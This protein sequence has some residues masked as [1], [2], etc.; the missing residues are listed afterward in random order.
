MAFGDLTA[1]A[2]EKKGLLRLMLKKGASS[3]QMARAEQIIKSGRSKTVDVVLALSNYS[4]SHT[5]FRDLLTRVC[6]VRYASMPLFDIDM[7]E[8]A[9]NV[10]WRLLKRR[11]REVARALRAAQTVIVRTANGS[12]I[13]VS[14]GRRRVYEDNGMLRKPGAFGN[15][16]AG[17]A[18]FAPMEGSACGTLVV[19]WAPSGRIA[20]PLVLVV[21]EGQVAD[22]IGDDAYGSFLREMVRSR[23]D[24]GTIAEF[25]VGTN[26]M[27]TRPG[28]ILEAEK[29]LGTVHVAIGDNSTFGGTVK[30][31][32]HQDFVIFKPTVMLVDGR[33][34][35]S[36]L[37]E[38]G[39]YSLEGIEAG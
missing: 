38:S 21:R 36:M 7:F 31:P 28:N 39:R 30:T 27:A 22:I 18:F 11:T 26:E 23:R 24:N 20:P 35:Q 29:I 14:R 19:E 4:T 3:E 37:M 10:D 15:L 16:P 5:T 32:F 1:E 9:M 34:V 6:G 8:G 12:D 33:G 13:R 17:E 2:L 25:G